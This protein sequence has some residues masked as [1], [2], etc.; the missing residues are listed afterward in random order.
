MQVGHSGKPAHNGPP[1]AVAPDAPVAKN[2]HRKH[3]GRPSE[4]PQAQQQHKMQTP[5]NAAKPSRQQGNR[6]P[7]TAHTVA[8]SAGAGAARHAQSNG[9][10]A[11]GSLQNRQPPVQ[12]QKPVRRSQIS[13]SVNEL[14]DRPDLVIS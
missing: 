7:E 9:V 8:H 10:H 5:R 11:A 13:K 4:E 12:T 3:Q 14:L 6:T 2:L 1:S